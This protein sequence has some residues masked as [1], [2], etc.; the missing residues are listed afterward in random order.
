MNI[1]DTSIATVLKQTPKN[2]SA[3]SDSHSCLAVSLVSST[4]IQDLLNTRNKIKFKRKYVMIMRFELPK[5]DC[6]KELS[7]FMHDDKLANNKEINEAKKQQNEN[8]FFV[9]AKTH[10]LIN[11]FPLSKGEI[12]LEENAKITPSLAL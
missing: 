2:A 3:L 1:T 6:S 5:F 10:S 12:Q 11:A 8:K 7:S 4:I 9:Q